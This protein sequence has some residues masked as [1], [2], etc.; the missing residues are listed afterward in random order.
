[1]FTVSI[2]SCADFEDLS[3]GCILKGCLSEKKCIAPKFSEYSLKHVHSFYSD[4]IKVFNSISLRIIQKT[5]KKGLQIYICNVTV[6]SWKETPVWNCHVL[7]TGELKKS[8]S[9]CS[10]W[11]GFRGILTKLQKHLFLTYIEIQ[12]WKKSWQRNRHISV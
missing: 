9:D 7:Q 10:H 5:D 3:P 11:S 12:S 8:Y 4:C 1:M 2:K 6:S